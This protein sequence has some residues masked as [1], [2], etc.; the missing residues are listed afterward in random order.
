VAEIQ[1]TA[2]MIEAGLAELK[3]SDFR[4]DIRFDTDESIVV[5]IFTAMALRAPHVLRRDTQ[6]LAYTN[7]PSAVGKNQSDKPSP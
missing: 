2:E 4:E 6:P 3:A 7:Q 5:G 1:V